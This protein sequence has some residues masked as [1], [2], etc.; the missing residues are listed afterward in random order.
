MEGRCLV[1]ETGGLALLAGDARLP[2]EHDAICDRRLGQPLP[3]R[4]I[5]NG[6]QGLAEIPSHLVRKRCIRSCVVVLCWRYRYEALWLIAYE[7]I[8]G[9]VG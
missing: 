1:L 2:V 6:A 9:K 4:R 3:A 7:A 8:G 5:S